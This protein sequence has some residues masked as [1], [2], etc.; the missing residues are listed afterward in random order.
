MKP[1]PLS[2]W[3]PSLQHVI[4]DMQGRPL[5]VH[6][7]LAYQPEF[8]A[9]WWQVR[10]YV[11]SGGDLARRDRELII[12]RVAANLGVWYEW[13]AHVDRALTAGIPIHE[14]ERIRMSPTDPEWASWSENETAL[15]RAV[16]QLVEQHVIDA[17]ALASLSAHYTR[18]QIVDIIAIQG[19]YVNL[20]CVINTW[21]PE[22]E[23]YVKARLPDQVTRSAFESEVSAPNG[24]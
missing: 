15:L 1:L 9:A 10:K 5:N 14:I 24:D 22:L 11:V 16:D 6:A 8:L 18:K 2:D 20:A 21:N 7:L 4:D 3:D 12:L 23:D 13:G 19:V 17:D